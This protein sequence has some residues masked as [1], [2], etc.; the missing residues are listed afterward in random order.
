MTQFLHTPPSFIS[1]PAHG[2]V[3]DEEDDD[4]VQ[5][6]EE[7]GVMDDEDADMEDADEAERR[8]NERIGLADGE[9]RG[10]TAGTS[11]TRWQLAG[12][13]GVPA[14]RARAMCIQQ[15]Q[16]DNQSE[17]P[18]LDCAACAAVPRHMCVL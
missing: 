3:Q 18:G 13:G 7:E 8:A 16:L 4:E 17:D 6:E 2:C 5:E 12:G 15:L 11:C 9:H 1:A 10:S 14:G